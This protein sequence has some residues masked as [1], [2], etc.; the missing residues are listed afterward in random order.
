MKEKEKA[1]SPLGKE[2]EAPYGGVPQGWIK[3][4]RPNP[5]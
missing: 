1:D 5:A 3:K 2:T 4:G